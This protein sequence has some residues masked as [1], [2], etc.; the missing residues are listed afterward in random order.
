[1][2]MREYLDL[3]AVSA[4]VITD[5]IDECPA[6]AWW[7]SPWNPDRPRESSKEADI[8]TI[9]HAMLLEGTDG[10]VEVIDPNDYPAATTGSIPDGWTN[11]AIRKA[12]D[13]ARERGKIPVLSTKIDE[14]EA[15]VKAA[16]TFLRA[17]DKT[18]PAIFDTFLPG[19][20]V[21]E[22]TYRWEEDGVL[23][24]MRPDRISLDGALVVNYKSTKTSIAPLAWGRW[25][26]LEHLVGAS[27]YRRG[28]KKLFGVECAYVFLVQSSSPPYLCSMIGVDPHAFAFGAG[29][30]EVGLRLWQECE[31]K[32]QWPGYPSRVCYPE[33]PPWVESQWAERE[34]E[35]VFHT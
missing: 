10:G 18:E 1:M 19:G 12:R 34:A 27:W 11:A 21:S 16:R 29:K 31:A 24:K 25:Q 14:V 23:C 6:V 8:G 9:A 17:L 28:I 33:L 26:F 13:E 5:L 2:K 4:G 7:N 35:N 22:E 20:G 15:M 30:V 3:K 32:N